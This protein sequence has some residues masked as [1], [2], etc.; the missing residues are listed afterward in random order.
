MLGEENANKQQSEDIIMTKTEDPVSN[1]SVP[2]SMSSNMLACSSQICFTQHQTKLISQLSPSDPDIIENDSYDQNLSSQAFS[3]RSQH[4]CQLDEHSSSWAALMDLSFYNCKLVR[5]ENLLFLIGGSK[6]PQG[7][8]IMDIVK[9]YCI[10]SGKLIAK[11]S[12]SYKR[13]K[14]GVTAVQ[15]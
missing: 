11:R 5:L 6:D 12:M 15:L 1:L 3:I 7:F 10:D 14:L 8:E 13:C 2:F 9:C 4:L